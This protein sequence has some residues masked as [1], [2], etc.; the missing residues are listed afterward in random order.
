MS[1][2]FINKPFPASVVAK[3]HIGYNQTS[4]SPTRSQRR[5]HLHPDKPGFGYHKQYI[6]KIDVDGTHFKFIPHINIPKIG[7]IPDPIM[8]EIFSI[9]RT[10][11][12]LGKIDRKIKQ[13]HA[14]V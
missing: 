13:S 2:K 12:E 10:L 14:N 6:Q 11:R 4:F 5:S 3:F 7:S 9:D 1:N 8:N